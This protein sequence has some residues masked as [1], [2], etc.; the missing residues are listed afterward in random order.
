LTRALAG[1]FD[2]YEDENGRPWYRDPGA[3]PAE[4][5]WMRQWNEDQIDVLTSNG[6]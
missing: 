6:R 1:H 4:P 5:E 3:V 2:R